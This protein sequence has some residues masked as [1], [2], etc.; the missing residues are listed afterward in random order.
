[1]E[2]NLPRMRTTNSTYEYVSNI[3]IN[4]EISIFEKKNSFP[5]VT[6][7][8]LLTGT[9]LL[10]C[11]R[12]QYVYFFASIKIHIC[13]CVCF[14]LYLYLFKFVFDLLQFI[15]VFVCSTCSRTALHCSGV[16]EIETS[17][18]KISFSSSILVFD[19]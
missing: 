15:F 1:M 8:I 10:R 19:T 5:T 16:S 14:N 7:V 13:I 17:M 11:D 4:L 12:D 2:S 18:S 9:P 6:V 3:S